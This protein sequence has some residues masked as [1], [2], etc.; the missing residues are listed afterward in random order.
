MLFFPLVLLRVRKEGQLP[1]IKGGA[2]VVANHGSYLDIPVLTHVL[3]RDHS[4]L[5][6]SSLNSVPLFGYMYRNLHILVDRT[7]RQSKQKSIAEAKRR[8]EAGRWVVFFPEGT[9]RHAIQPGLSDMKDGAFHLAVQAQVPIVPIT[10]PY[11]WYIFPDDDT[12]LGRWV[13]PLA[14]IH[15]AIA[16][17]GLNEEHIPMLKEQVRAIF[18]QDIAIYNRQ[19][20]YKKT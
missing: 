9:I 3:W 18:V 8:L 20:G 19:A 11:N 6:K 4:F 5:G 7:D 15:P 12:F 16:T 14:I 1:N 2:V 17:L 10:L 13:S